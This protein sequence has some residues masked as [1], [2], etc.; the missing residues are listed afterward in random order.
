M[1]ICALATPVPWA[2]TARRR[3]VIAHKDENFLSRR[4]LLIEPLAEGGFRLTNLSAKLAIRLP[5]GNE[6][7]PASSC[8]LPIPASLTLGKK[9]VRIQPP[10]EAGPSNLQSLADVTVP[11]ELRRT[12]TWPAID[13]EAALVTAPPALRK[14]P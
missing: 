13:P 8:E 3:V 1:W 12:P 4:H 10:E 14:T 9:F 5:D 11:P 6:L 2:A 7:A